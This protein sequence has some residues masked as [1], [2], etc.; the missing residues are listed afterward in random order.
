ML[1]VILSLIP[2]AVVTMMLFVIASPLMTVDGGGLGGRYVVDS[3]QTA[4]AAM[5]WWQGAAAPQRAIET[6]TSIGYILVLWG[7][8]GW[9]SLK[10]AAYG[11]GRMAGILAVIGASGLGG[12]VIDAYGIESQVWLGLSALAFFGFLAVGGSTLIRSQ[13][14]A[15]VSQHALAHLHGW[16]VWPSWILLSGLGVIW[17]MDLAARGPHQLMLIGLHQLD[18]LWL[19]S[20]L[21]MPFML[22][23]HHALLKSGLWLR[24]IWRTPRGPLVT[25]IVLIVMLVFCIW[26]GRYATFGHQRGFPHQSAELIR[27]LIALSLAWL[28]SRYAEWGAADSRRAAAAGLAF[29]MMLG[30]VSSLIISG[31]LGPVL[32]MLLGGLPLVVAIL[33]PRQYGSQYGVRLIFATAC[34]VGLFAVVQAGLMVWMP[35]SSWAPQRLVDRVE[36]TLS[37]FDAR[38]DF[39][40]QFA[41]LLDAATTQGFGLVSVPWCGAMPMLGLGNCTNTSG[42]PV[43][44][45]SDYVFV[46]LAALWGRYAATAIASLTAL[47]FVALAFVSLPR[48]N[49]QSPA[50]LPTALLHAWIVVAFAAL[51]L[52]QLVVSTA[53]NVGVIPV[54]GITQPLL[55]LGAVSLCAMAAWFGFALGGATGARTAVAQTVDARQPFGNEPSPW[56]S[57]AVMSMFVGVLILLAG[58]ITWSVHGDLPVRDQLISRRVEHGLAL[59]TCHRAGKARLKNAACEK[60]KQWPQSS[61]NPAPG[62]CKKLQ[63]QLPQILNSIT[64]RTSVPL[65]LPPGLTCTEVDALNA[66]SSW[67]RERGGSYLTTM[68]NTPARLHGA[69]LAVVNPYRVPGCL[70]FSQAQGDYLGDTSDKVLCGSD[71]VTRLGKHIPGISTLDQALS[72]AIRAVREPRD[73]GTGGEVIEQK[74]AS[75]RDMPQP[76]WVGRLGINRWLPTNLPTPTIIGQG[77][78]LDISIAPPIQSTVQGIADCYT[79]NSAALGCKSSG[80]GVMLEG[81]RAR[82][83]GI[84]VVD[85]RSGEIQGAASAH[86]PCYA[87]QYSGQKNAD[88]LRLPEVPRAR[89]WMLSNHALNSVAMIGSLDKMPLALGLIQSGSPLGRDRAQM[90]LAIGRSETERFIDDVMCADHGF[91]SACITSRLQ[92][93]SASADAIGWQ[94]RCEAGDAQCGKINLLHDSDGLNYSVPA[95][96]WLANPGRSTQSLSQS[97]SPGEREFAREAIAA[98]Y[99]HKSAHRWRNC[100]GRQLVQVVAELFGQGNA[101]STPVGIAEGLLGIVRRAQ[102][103]ANSQFAPGLTL[104]AR[105]ADQT[106]DSA[107]RRPDPAAQALLQDMENTILTGGTANSACLHVENM[108][109]SHA[110]RISCLQPG[111]WVLSSKTGT[112]LFPH[113]TLTYQQRE[114]HCQHIKTQRDSP[115]KRHELVHCQVPPVKWFASVMGQKRPDGRIDWQKIII[116]IAERNWNAST[117]LIDTPLDRGSSVA[118]EVALLAAN[119]MIENTPTTPA[120]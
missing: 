12:A 109:G 41:W 38:L 120:Q 33:I 5:L 36:A 18:A 11:T 92:L 17:L 32:A 84:L 72:R 68:L 106:A 29:T 37:P 19:A 113:D 91:S 3:L 39:A 112:P 78:R 23:A 115:S 102:P 59:L 100:K 51:S 117:G 105:D 24:E 25:G 46:G 88:C 114:R 44:L 50:M 20:L 62:R 89:E 16:W 66:V 94:T 2:I 96:R 52:G 43:Q 67:A 93:I 26:L 35:D 60:L 31:D 61:D 95:A 64:N 7:V 76:S 49:C 90:A 6:S 103:E 83:M 40:A 10:A 98:C 71:G 27:V 8:L 57:R 4:Q 85:A 28:M 75:P 110:F 14:N 79:G 22:W 111:E 97:V 80:G 116:V 56:V 77:H 30:V 74:I 42:V 81:A 86:S 70:Q 48:R 13:R 82:M 21:V 87:A 107:P 58:L 65:S 15:T 108:L 45:G 101:T 104:L 9:I 47:L 54:S 69:K 55:G 118:A 34:L 53:G 119:R 1:K 63:E 73:S 99:D